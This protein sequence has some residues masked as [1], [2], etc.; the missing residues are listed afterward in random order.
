MAPPNRASTSSGPALNTW[1]VSFVS[2]SSF[3]K[4]P[5]CTP[6]SAAAWVTFAK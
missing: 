5:S 1:V 6:I 2:P 4:S 3:S